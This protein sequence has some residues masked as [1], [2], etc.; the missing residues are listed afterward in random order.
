[1]QPSARQVLTDPVHFFAFGFG[2]GLLR[3]GPGTF[4]TL[5]GLPVFWL[6]YGQTMI[7]Y[8]GAIVMMFCLG[9][10]LCGESAR[11]LG[12]HDHGGI[13]WDEI[14]GLQVTLLPLQAGL[15]ANASVPSWGWVVVGF[16]LF[17][18]FDIAKPPPVRWADRNIHGG[19]GIMFDDLIA[20]LYAGSAMTLVLLGSSLA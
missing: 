1:M 8:L 7:V 12:V 14:V 5:A 4:G 11:R 3:P 10:F 2:A 17:R 19:F 6:L 9:I 18:I 15:P 13:V 20:A 16:V